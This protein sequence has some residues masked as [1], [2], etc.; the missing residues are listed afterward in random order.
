MISSAEKTT[1]SSDFL[2][3]SFLLG[4]S[5]RFS[6]REFFFFQREM[7]PAQVIR[8]PERTW[9][10]WRMKLRS[11]DDDDVISFERRKMT[12]HSILHP[13]LVGSLTRVESV[14]LQFLLKI[15]KYHSW[16]MEVSLMS[17]LIWLCLCD[18]RNNVAWH[19][20]SSERMLKENK[21][22]NKDRQIHHRKKQRVRHK[23]CTERNESWKHWQRDRRQRQVKKEL[24]LHELWVT[25]P[26]S[27][28]V[29]VSPVMSL[30]LL[31]LLDFVLSKAW[32]H[33]SMCH[34]RSLSLFALDED[35]EQVPPKHVCLP[36]LPNKNVYPTHPCHVFLAKDCQSWVTT[37]EM[38]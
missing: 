5:R 7:T 34:P 18:L 19:S 21:I 15:Q 31:S 12:F 28:F 11:I 16:A 22:K 17:S 27:S 33:C 24:S 30:S 10:E 26:K 3:R 9:E 20:L 38:S 8:K 32:R 25:L 4:H 23:K 37:K 6:K 29:C 13:S 36:L 2:S 1:T 14:S 35:D